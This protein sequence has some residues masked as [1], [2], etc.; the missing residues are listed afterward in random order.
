M[1]DTRKEL[2]IADIKASKQSLLDEGFSTR[3]PAV[4]VHDRLLEL[5]D[6]NARERDANTPPEFILA[7]LPEE[8]KQPWDELRSYVNKTPAL[9]SL[10]YDLDL[11][12]E[13]IMN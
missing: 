7:D 10:L 4:L 5:E 2:T 3:S 11:M 6:A 12:P 8:L 9:L 13:Q 1:T